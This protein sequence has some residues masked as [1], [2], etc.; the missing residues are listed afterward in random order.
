VIYE[1]ESLCGPCAVAVLDERHRY[2]V[3]KVGPADTEEE[4]EDTPEPTG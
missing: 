3:V 4:E 1:Q 2:L